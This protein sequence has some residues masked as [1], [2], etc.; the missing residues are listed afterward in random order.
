[1]IVF[2]VIVQV[3]VFLLLEDVKVCGVFIIFISY[4][5]FV[6]V[7]FVDDIFVMC[8]GEVV[9]QGVVV[10]VFGVL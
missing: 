6:V 7:Q 5:F 9:E 3:Q 10:Q 4:D 2:D 8:E 1:M